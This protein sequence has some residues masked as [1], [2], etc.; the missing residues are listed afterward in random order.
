MR[1][2]WRK[3]RSSLKNFFYGLRN[4]FDRGPVSFIFSTIWVLFL[5]FIV[6]TILL[7]SFRILL[8]LIMVSAPEI[9]HFINFAWIG[10]WK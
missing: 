6:L 3:G 8:I 5:A 9:M 1:K 4:D 2:M 7:A 10:V